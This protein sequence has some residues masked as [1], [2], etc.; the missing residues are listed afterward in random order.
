[1]V[2]GM[3]ASSLAFLVLSVQNVFTPEASA[4]RRGIPR[5][6]LLACLGS[7]HAGGSRRQV[8]TRFTPNDFFPR[9]HPSNADISFR[10]QHGEKSHEATLLVQS[11]PKRARCLHGHG[12]ASC[13][14]LQS[15]LLLFLLHSP[16]LL[17]DLQSNSQR[18]MLY[19]TVGDC[20]F[21]ISRR[22]RNAH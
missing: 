13:D 6:K 19:T 8:E 12:L 1:M 7:Y 21:S 22:M 4:R 14:A 17:I 2:S 10:R 15:L 11:Y 9:A 5:S 20:I 16:L 18:N 3:D